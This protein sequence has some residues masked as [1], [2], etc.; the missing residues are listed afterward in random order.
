M[1]TIAYAQ[2]LF[3]C[4]FPHLSAH[5]KRS[6][7]FLNFSR[8]LAQKNQ[9]F[10]EFFIEQDNHHVYIHHFICS[11]FHIY[12]PFCRN[13][14]YSII[15]PVYQPIDLALGAPKKN[16]EDLCIFQGNYHV[17]TTIFWSLFLHLQAFF[18]ESHKFINFWH[19]MNIAPGAPKFYFSKNFMRTFILSWEIITYIH[20]I[21][22]SAYFYIYMLFLG[23]TLIPQYLVCISSWI[24]L[25]KHPK[26]FSQNFVLSQET[27]TYTHTIFSPSTHLRTIFQKSRK[28]LNFRVYLAH[29]C[30]AR[31]TQ[32]DFLK[33]IYE[34]LC[35]E[36]RN[37]H[38][39][40]RYF[41]SRPFSHLHTIFL[42][43]V[44][45]SYFFACISPLIK[46]PGAQKKSQKNLRGHSY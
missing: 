9:K 38:I 30:G 10:Y 36:T 12:N 45:I 18:Y 42:G 17:Y 15:F 4:P 39:Y 3:T 29:K 26:C 5:F 6:R 14:A 7:K 28:F 1:G 25:P 34:N 21:C 24:Q 44:Q 40:S 41:F 23:I 27:I 22:Y 32:K 13:I 46:V 16:Y 2:N 43:I 37:H 20:T 35:I 11:N 31:R 33:K 19:D 8:L